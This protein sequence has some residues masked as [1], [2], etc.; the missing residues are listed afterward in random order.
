MTATVPAGPGRSGRRRRR[1]SAA[2][3]L[4]R[5]ELRRNAMPWMLP[6]IAALFW[7]LTYRRSMALPPLWNVRA[8]S[9]QGTAIAV[10]IPTVVGAAAWMGSREARRGLTDLLA[11]TARPRWAR[12]FAAWA[13]TTGW[14]LVGYLVCVGRPV[15]GHRV[16]GVLG[17]PA[18]VAGRGRRGEPAG[19]GRARVRR[20]GAASPAGSPHRWSRSPRS[21]R[22]KSACSSS[23]AP[24]V[25]AG[26][27]AGG[28]SLGPRHR[29]RAWRRSTATFPTCPIAQLMFLAGLTAALL[30]VLGCPPAPVGRGCAG[31]PPPSPRPASWL[32]GR[33][34][35]WP[36]PAGSTR[37]A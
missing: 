33:P 17:R 35:R 23:T 4:L 21:S 29:P 12:Q 32:P 31:R 20:R 7:F 36:A 8:M 16:P 10:F 11:V 22:W 3:R 14:A 2:G 24:V 26:L 37:T 9:M 6:L 15:R 18:V 1:L 30:G 27:A 5:L 28:R 13:A 34:S 19:A 25:L